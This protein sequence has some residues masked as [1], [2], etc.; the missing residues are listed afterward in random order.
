MTGGGSQRKNHGGTIGRQRLSGNPALIRAPATIAFIGL[1]K[2]GVPMA[3]RLLG[4][5]YRLRGYDAADAARTRF[6]QAYPQAARCGMANECVEGAAAVITML[7]D[8]KAVAEVLRGA[9]SSIAADAIVIDMSSS[10]PI[11]TEKTGVALA[12]RGIAM[13]DAPVSGGVKRA[14]DGT[15]AIMAGG[16]AAAVERCLPVLNAMGGAV[17]RTGKLGSGH[18]MKALNNAV[19]AAGLVA[20][21]EALLIGQRFGLDPAVMVDV[22]NASTGK[23]NST[24]N[25]LK[26]H[27]LS[28]SF[29]SGFAL[30]LMAKDLGTAA[31]LARHLEVAAPLSAACTRLWQAARAELGDGADHTEI[32]RYI[33]DIDD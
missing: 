14:L 10:S 11:D 25:K 18:A 12:A 33:R 19:S 5:G 16:D 29:A 3:A 31:E 26:Q 8:G 1:G 7:P 4:A 2:M 21:A 27:I 28:G 23:N 17:F 9:A 32:F 15:L 24:E 13:I 30:G 6:A 22:L 20:A